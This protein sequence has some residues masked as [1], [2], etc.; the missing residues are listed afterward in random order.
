MQKIDII[1]SIVLY[2]NDVEEL[3]EAI[4]SFLNTSLNV[5]LYLIDNS[6]T[7]ELSK[8]FS[9]PKIEYIFNNGNIGFGAG[10]NVA[11]KQAKNDNC[12]Y[13]LIINPDIYFEKGQLEKMLNYMDSEEGKNVGLLMPKI[14]YPNGDIQYVCKRNARPIDLIYNRLSFLKFT[15]KRLDS[16]KMK[17][18]G[19]NSIMEVDHLSGCFLFARHEALITVNGFDEKFFMYFEDFDLTNRVRKKYKTIFFP[20]A[21]IYHGY[22]RESARNFKL[23]MILLQSCR[24]YFSKYG[25]F[26]LW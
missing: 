7:N 1:G 16:F 4:E 10:H 2:Q 11:I 19:Y 5:K 15:E 12:E 14:L 9:D 3:K 22:N 23:M 21:I 20:D 13:F 24:H 25:W 6:P 8:Q 26:P 17:E 18:T